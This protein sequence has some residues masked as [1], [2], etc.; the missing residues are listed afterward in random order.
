MEQRKLLII[1]VELAV[2]PALLIFLDEPT[3]GL[4]SQSL[5][6]YAF[7]YENRLSMVKRCCR[8]S[9]NRALYSFND[10]PYALYCKGREAC[11]FGDIEEQSRAPSDYFE[12]TG[13]RVCASSENVWFSLACY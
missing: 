12:G 5:R 6:P 1:G 13:A 3:R 9:I 2:R 10:R 11:Y 7:F 4:D 8:L